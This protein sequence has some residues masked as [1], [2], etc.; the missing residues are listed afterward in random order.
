MSI[1]LSEVWN[2]VGKGWRHLNEQSHNVQNNIKHLESS[3]QHISPPTRIIDW[4][5]GGGYLSRYI[6]QKFQTVNT[7]EFIDI[8][9][10]HFELVRNTL[11]SIPIVIGHKFVDIDSVKIN[12]NP[13]LLIAYSVIYHMPSIKY[14]TD[15]L[16]YWNSTLQP[17]EIVIRNMFNKHNNWERKPNQYSVGNNFLRGNLIS[18]E[19]FATKMNNYIFI[20]KEKIQNVKHNNCSVDHID[21]KIVMKRK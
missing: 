7:I 4:G 11:N 13:D 2:K 17:K 16:E 10:D 1:N 5:P 21:M 12:T 14:V 18:L 9:D 3:I 15:I 19:Y 6:S 8:C 20:E